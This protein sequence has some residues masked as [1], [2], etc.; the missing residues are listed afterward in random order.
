MAS[1]LDT[2]V[3]K[4]DQTN[5]DDLIGGRTMTITITNVSIKMDE[6]PVTIHFDGD[7]GK[8]Y[9]PGKSMRRVLVNVWGPDAKAYI[10]RKLTLYRDDSV[11]FG[12]MDVGGLRISHMS[13]IT[14]PVT[15]ALTA[16]KAQRRPF[17]VNPLVEAQ[18]SSGPPKKTL[19]QWFADLVSDFLDAGTDDAAVQKVIDREDVQ[20]ALGTLKA[21][22]LEK[23]QAMI[24]TYK[25]EWV[26]AG[27]ETTPAEE[28]TEGEQPKKPDDTFPGDLP[29]REAAE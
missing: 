14:E 20:R 3:P 7:N 12:G 15:M 24:K 11:K 19:T 6:Q 16:T 8:P 26:V 23:L 21:A 5:A 13:G 9:K 29:S 18:Q 17:T 2:I 28:S 22:N 4:S 25:P 10:G 1:M 27:A